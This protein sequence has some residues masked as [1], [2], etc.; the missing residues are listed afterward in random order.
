LVGWPIGSIM[1]GTS[2]GV[3]VHPKTVHATNVCPMTAL[4]TSPVVARIALADG[5][6]WLVPPGASG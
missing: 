3:P 4:L 1:V 5:S 2:F 6:M